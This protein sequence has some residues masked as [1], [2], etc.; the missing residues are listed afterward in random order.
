[1]FL[2]VICMSKW[3]QTSD[4]YK[5]MILKGIWNEAHHLTSGNKMLACLDLQ[6]IIWYKRIMS[7]FAFNNINLIILMD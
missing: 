5:D 4:S 2:V 6:R 7:S 1:M 3:S